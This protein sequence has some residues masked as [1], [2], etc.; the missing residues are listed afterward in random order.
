MELRDEVLSYDPVMRIALAF[1]DFVRN[2]KDW[3]NRLQNV[4]AK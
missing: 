1:Y 4:V 2:N 3:H